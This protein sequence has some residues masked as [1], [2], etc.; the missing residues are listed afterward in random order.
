[1]DI[2]SSFPSSLPILPKKEERDCLDYL[3]VIPKR[4]TCP[5][6]LD[7]GGEH[8]IEFLPEAVGIF[9]APVDRSL[10]ELE[11]SWAN[12]Q[13]QLDVDGARNVT[14]KVRQL[15][16]TIENAKKS[17]CLDLTQHLQSAQDY[18]KTCEEQLDELS[19]YRSEKAKE[20]ETFEEVD[21]EFLEARKVE[22]LKPKEE[23]SYLRAAFNQK[24][25][26]WIE[27]LTLLHADGLEKFNVPGKGSCLVHSVLRS[28]RPGANEEDGLAFRT[29]FV[30]DMQRVLTTDVLTKRRRFVDSL[31]IT[32][33][34]QEQLTQIK[35]Y[36][37]DMSNPNRW[38]GEED[39]CILAEVLQRP[40]WVFRAN[41]LELGLDGKLQPTNN[42]RY[43][44]A[45]EGEPIRLWFHENHY[46]YF[47]TKEEAARRAPPQEESAKPESTESGTWTGLLAKAVATTVTKTVATTVT[48]TATYAAGKVFSMMGW[49]GTSPDALEM[50]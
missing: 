11:K 40:I 28:I 34:L 9:A 16:Q 7:V 19:E 1:M 44:A 47:L 21:P 3:D 37:E 35:G 25:E 18:L 32:G 27:S 29:A 2:S 14:Q 38:L 31:M 30:R 4:P 15:K 6:S 41:N 50:V 49:G 36:C 46:Q 5:L 23:P 17:S 22:F 26:Q 20:P 8:Y 10:K 43:G 45:Q 33:T 39:L 42:F 24:K 13:K 12:Y 48:K